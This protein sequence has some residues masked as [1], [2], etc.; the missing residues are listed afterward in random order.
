MAWF[1]EYENRFHQ[2]MPSNHSTYL[3]YVCFPIESVVKEKIAESKK[4]CIHSDKNKKILKI[5]HSRYE[6]SSTKTNTHFR[7]V[8]SSGQ[9]TSVHST[10]SLAYTFK[11]TSAQSKC[12]GR[13]SLWIV[14]SGERW[15]HNNE[16]TS[17]LAPKKPGI[18]LLIWFICS[19]HV[20][21]SYTFKHMRL[22]H[23]FDSNFQTKAN[24]VAN[25]KWHCS[26]WSVEMIAMDWLEY[27]QIVSTTRYKHVLRDASRATI[28]LFVRK[29][30]YR[31]SLAWLVYYQIVQRN[32]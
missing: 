8:F 30:F 3:Q 5:L 11:K 24:T 17:G 14:S 10:G 21:H 12:F 16:Q 4:V 23:H 2:R 19:T 18:S 9:P 28:Y 20:S 26:L 13:A 29:N 32:Q 22:I 31:G 1:G 27:V 6:I 7:K 25:C 15:P